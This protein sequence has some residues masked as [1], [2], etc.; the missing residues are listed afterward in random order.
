MPFSHLIEGMLSVK[1]GTALRSQKKRVTTFFSTTCASRRSAV[2]SPGA[3]TDFGN[4]HH[5][6]SVVLSG[7]TAVRIDGPRLL[8]G[9]AFFL[10]L[11][12]GRRGG[13]TATGGDDATARARARRTGAAFV[14]FESS[15]FCA[16]QLCAP[17]S[18]Q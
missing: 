6:A 15:A 1:P 2:H 5:A 14:L 4:A 11:V 3:S 9:V 10:M 7:S 12:H 13:A 16:R 8:P 17:P 18:V